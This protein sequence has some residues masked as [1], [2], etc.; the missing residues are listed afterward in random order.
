MIQHN[1][2]HAIYQ[3]YI[4]IKKYFDNNPDLQK[5]YT[6]GI[7]RS[8]KARSKLSNLSDNQFLELCTDVNDELERR[9][10][11]EAK[12]SG[13]H[14]AHDDTFFDKR[15]Q[16]RRKL[17]DLSMD[18]FHDLI[19][20]IIHEVERRGFHNGDD[21]ST[22]KRQQIMTKFSFIPN[23]EY[24]NEAINRSYADDYENLVKSPAE[25]VQTSSIMPVKASIDW[26]SEEET[27]VGT[28]GP[29][30]K[31]QNATFKIAGESSN[32][33]KSYETDLESTQSLEK[34]IEKV[35]SSSNN[36]VSS[37]EDTKIGKPEVEYSNDYLMKENERL[38]KELEVLKV[39]KVQGKGGR[40]E[41]D[42]LS[43]ESLKTLIDKDGYIP[44]SLVEKY[45]HLANTFFQKLYVEQHEGPH[46][47]DEYQEPVVMNGTKLFKLIF[48]L[49][50]VISD[51]ILLVD[52]PE[53]QLQ[54]KLLRTSIS[55][56][57]T[58]L[59]YYSQYS[60][61]LP[62][63]TVSVAISDISFA[64]CNLIGTVKLKDEKCA[65]IGN[66][67]ISFPAQ[68]FPINGDNIHNDNEA[69]PVKPLKFT[70]KVNSN[71][72]ISSDDSR[73]STLK[74]SHRK[75]LF[76]ALIDY[77]TPTKKGSSEKKA[78]GVRDPDL[79]ADNPIMRNAET[80][81]LYIDS[82]SLTVDIP[83][84]PTSSNE[85][86]DEFDFMR[87]QDRDHE[88]E[89]EKFD[90]WETSNKQREIEIASN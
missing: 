44:F 10:D 39:Q 11:I 29:D 54:V 50:K 72:D 49:S 90:D 35:I 37:L 27:D 56:A 4:E 84:S 69:S 76:K 2:H 48:Q 60:N 26:S 40:N 3:Y 19:T 53:Y 88:L 47:S 70:Q 79:V 43:L 80:S 63:M 18:R 62:K 7:R 55:H 83:E 57:I 58:S 86:S 73:S 74:G 30:P 77:T 66:E 52:L 1:Y 75:G 82:K 34:K 89:F 67:N 6:G 12:K 15:N 22:A 20:D 31:E 68:D 51:I 65:N 59:R 16:A 13:K 24:E 71:T 33:N 28:S 36:S 38:K 8:E 85:D 78:Q 14:L 21:I 23:E 42:S 25:S 46:L 61:L 87:F 45:H 81:S 5:G 41:Q 64:L 32:Q 17:G 9:L